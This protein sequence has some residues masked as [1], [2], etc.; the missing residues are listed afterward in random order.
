MN[1][2]VLLDLDNTIICTHFEKD[3]Q[4]D[5]NYDF[6][7]NLHNRKYAVLI[8]PHLDKF[9]DYLFDNFLVYVWTSA[10]KEYAEIIV[11]KVIKRKV[12]IL[13]RSFNNKKYIPSNIHD[14]EDITSVHKGVYNIYK[15]YRYYQNPKKAFETILQMSG[16]FIDLKRIRKF[17]KKFNYQ[18]KDIIAI[19]NDP[20]KY[21]QDYGNYFY[22]SDY[23]GK[24]DNDLLNMI[25]LLEKVKDCDD[26]TKFK[27]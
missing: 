14:M 8:R 1:K 21:Y 17:I 23:Y 6:T 5:I 11:D 15:V 12:T 18:R 25:N 27:R 19:D 20:Y 10:T 16:K 7:F 2:V 22:I 4:D 3:I 26:V 13:D 24:P 9:L